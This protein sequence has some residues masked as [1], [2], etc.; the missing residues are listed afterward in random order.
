VRQQLVEGADEIHVSA[1]LAADGS[2]A[3]VGNRNGI[4]TFLNPA[5]A[6][7]VAR[8]DQSLG[9]FN[10]VRINPACDTAAAAGASG[11]M[12]LFNLHLERPPRRF[13]VDSESGIASLAY[14]PDGTLLALADRDGKCHFLDADTGLLIH[15]L[16]SWERGPTLR[17]WEADSGKELATF[18]PGGEMIFSAQFSR[19]GKLIYAGD[20]TGIIYSID[21]VYY[22]GRIEG[23]RAY[24]ARRAAQPNP[25]TS[26][27]SEPRR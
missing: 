25:I 17:I 23:N 21:L 5:D 3:V 24:Q 18:E 10:C 7:V 27:Q 6:S 2:V 20:N 16:A 19:D 13:H 22:D 12:V 11:D 4:V 1:D 8:Y 15:R 26:A 14:S 9:S